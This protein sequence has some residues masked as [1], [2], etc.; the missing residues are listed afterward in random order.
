MEKADYEEL[1]ESITKDNPELLKRTEK[2]KEDILMLKNHLDRVS[3][4][5][6]YVG[7]ESLVGQELLNL[8]DDLVQKT[9]STYGFPESFEEDFDWFIYEADFG[10][11]PINTEVSDIEV[12][13]REYHIN[14]L[15]D[16]LY[17]TIKEWEL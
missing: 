3:E 9:I 7:I 11:R 6:D 12:D 17:Y 14:S 15:N 8:Y 13:G 5:C 2:L 4:F 10:E 16:F 1:I